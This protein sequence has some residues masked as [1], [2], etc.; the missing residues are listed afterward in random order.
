MEKHGQ[1]EVIKM[2]EQALE[3]CSN[4]MLEK[5]KTY[6]V[7]EHVLSAKQVDDL[8]SKKSLIKYSDGVLRSV[9]AFFSS[10]IGIDP[11]EA[12]TYFTEISN[13][14]CTIF[15]EK[16]QKFLSDMYSDATDSTLSIY[17]KYCNKIM[18]CIEQRIGKDLCEATKEDIIDGIF[19]MKYRQR[20]TA[21]NCLNFIKSYLIWCKRSGDDVPYL[22]DI[23]SIGKD[24]LKI[25]L[26]V[27]HNLIESPAALANLLQPIWG[28]E[29]FIGCLSI[30]LCWL[31]LKVEETVVLEDCDVDIKN[32]SIHN[33]YWGDI[34][35][36]EEFAFFFD[37]YY[38]RISQTA[39]DAIMNSGY[40][41]G[42]SPK[43]IP[44]AYEHS[45]FFLK[46]SLPYRRKNPDQH[47]GISTLRN[48]ITDIDNYV[49]S[50]SNMVVS[51]IPRN[52]FISGAFYRLIDIEKG[53]KLTDNDFWHQLRLKPGTRTTDWKIEYSD[54]K[55][56]YKE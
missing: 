46:R 45:K 44:S 34:K 40:I 18:I 33:Q 20:H 4:D 32:L 29:T 26:G 37:S 52:V 28:E 6:M 27:T 16:K 8:I 50:H 54:F 49:K 47:Y 31:G 15:S 13:I 9:L 41:D 10:Y 51:I 24:D 3:T 56:A 17:K 22:D 48:K 5:F 38:D 39:S 53:R 30:L 1:S 36:P 14:D 42:K 21:A 55:T 25:D 2:M 35:I 12:S 43:K 19:R 11:Q 23:F 7:D